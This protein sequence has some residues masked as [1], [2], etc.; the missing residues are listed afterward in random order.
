MCLP[1]TDK[2]V[3]ILTHDEPFFNSNDTNVHIWKDPK[4]NLLRPKGRG[5]GIM[6]SEFLTLFGR[7]RCEVL[8]SR[9]SAPSFFNIAARE[10]V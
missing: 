8:V 1:D 9:F 5:K 10:H 3:M 6:A 7:L 4:T 2:P